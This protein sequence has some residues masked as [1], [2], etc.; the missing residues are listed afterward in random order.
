MITSAYRRLREIRPDTHLI[1]I[2]E[3]PYQKELEKQLS[4]LPVTFTGFLQGTELSQAIA[5]GDVK[6]FPSTTDT[7]GNAP[8]EAQASGL[9]VVVSDVGGPPELMLDGVTGLKMKGRDVQELYDA[10]VILMDGPTRSRMGQ[11]AR[12]FAEANRVEEPFTAILDSDT[13]RQRLQAQKDAES[14]DPLQLTSQLLDLTAL[15]REFEAALDGVL[16]A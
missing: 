12:T 5:S 11:L 15:H 1:F 14:H 9:P 10:M 8:L 4:G 2:G 13:Y 3:G 6:L 7:W 16:S